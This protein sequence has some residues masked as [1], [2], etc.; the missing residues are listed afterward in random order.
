MT[1][2]THKRLLLV[3]GMNNFLRCYVVNPSLDLN[4]NHVGGVVGFL[5][6]LK[7][8]MIQIMKLY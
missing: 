7:N 5:N 3:D 4:G 2:V 8:I 6:A 1:D